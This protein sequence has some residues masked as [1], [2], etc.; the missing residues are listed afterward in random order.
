MFAIRWNYLL[1][2]SFASEWESG[3]TSPEWPIHPDRVFQAL[4]AAWAALGNTPEHEDALRWLEALPPPWIITPCE[5]KNVFMAA[6]PEIFVPVNDSSEHTKKGR[7]FP[8]KCVTGECALV[9]KEASADNGRL[10]AFTTICQ[11]VTHIGMERSFVSMSVDSSY[12]RPADTECYYPSQDGNYRLR[13]AYKGRLDDLIADYADGG[14]NWKRPRVGKWVAYS[15]ESSRPQSREHSEFN[16]YDI[17]IYRWVDGIRLGLAQAPLVVK[18]FCRTLIKGAD[19]DPVAMRLISGHEADGTVIQYAHVLIFPIGDAVHEHAD[20]H[21]LGI[22]IALPRNFSYEET[23]AVKRAI[24][25]A[26]NPETGEICLTFGKIGSMTLASEMRDCPPLA[27]QARSWCRP[28]RDWTTIT[29]MVC[30]KMPPRSKCKYDGWIIA[31]IADACTKIGLPVPKRIEANAVGFAEGI[32]T[33]HEISPLARRENGVDGASRWHVHVKLCF[34]TPVQGPIILG[35][36]RYRG[37][38]I[39]KP[40]ASMEE[41]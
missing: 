30:N 12:N 8:A 22:G 32:P 35:A 26:E 27:M 33:C 4:T 5:N 11:A 3:R 25:Q 19:G 9:W 39:C 17:M 7:S 10:Q 38:G 18:T 16:P 37:Y 23:L 20:G 40:I 28:S 15:K 1:G 14:K 13:C 36:G 41:K 24:V 21:L 31:Q 6:N 2:K 29:P 34:E